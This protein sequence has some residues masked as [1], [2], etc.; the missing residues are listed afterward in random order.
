MARRDNQGIQIAMIVFILTTLLF[1]VT[2]YFGYS[3]TTTLQGEL[4]K[5]KSDLSSASGQRDTV[6]AASTNLK[7]FIGV[8]PGMDDQAALSQIEQLVTEDYGKGQPPV[9]QT[10]IGIIDDRN[11]RVTELSQ[12]LARANKQIQDLRGD[13]ATSRATAQK[14]LED[15]KSLEQKAHAD[16]QT[17]LQDKT[18]YI[19]E[20]DARNQALVDERNRMQSELA[21]TRS[22]TQKQ[23]AE[24]QAE[25]D[26]AIRLANLKQDE[27]NV[28][29]KDTPDKYD[30]RV[31]GAVAATRTV[32][33]N[34]G[35]AD[36]I[37]PK[38]TFGVYDADDNN[39]RTAKK[40]AS[41]EVT[42]VLG[43]H[44]SEA[45]ITE[46]DFI[47]PIVNDDYIYSPIWSPGTLLGV[48]LVGEMDFDKDGRDDRDYI[49]NLIARNGG[50]VDAEDVK[51][52]GGSE[53]NVM[54]GKMT[55]NTR[56]IIVG[57]GELRGVAND[58]LNEAKSLTI[59]RMSVSEL[60]DLISPPGRARSVVYGGAP[61]AGDFAPQAKN[62]VVSSSPGSTTSFRKRTPTPRRDR[63]ARTY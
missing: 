44:T 50:R 61:K 4:D 41:V 47:H 16:F 21:Q 42:R 11:T 29:K 37:R 54:T 49:R 32:L 25:R 27:L 13:L 59:E 35:R 7:T 19:T 18:S 51:D 3:S 52:P 24:A 5:A 39:V 38:T 34:V 36:G 22:D 60:L 6:V 8:D 53:D 28:I 30:G 17:A 1:M 45:R 23:L 31:I 55:V 56:Y 62:G 40:K 48:A 43:D 2:T 63:P 12:E 9:S 46:T 15:A 58:M 57:D 33:L 14:Q 20:N 26:G 10:L